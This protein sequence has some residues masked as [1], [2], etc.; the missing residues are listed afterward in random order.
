MIKKYAQGI[1]GS[2]QFSGTL[3]PDKGTW[4]QASPDPRSPD[5]HLT[6]SPV[7]SKQRPHTLGEI[8]CLTALA[9]TS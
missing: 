9:E 3:E 6:V 1:P 7:P 2:D 5:L 8:F 4:D